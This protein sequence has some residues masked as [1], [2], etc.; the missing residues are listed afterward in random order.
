MKKYVPISIYNT[1]L[2][3]DS[4]NDYLHVV[5]CTTG[6]THTRTPTMAVY[7][8]PDELL[9]THVHGPN[10]EIVVVP[11]GRGLSIDEDYIVITV[12][13]ISKRIHYNIILYYTATV[14]MIGKS[15]NVYIYIYI[16]TDSYRQKHIAAVVFKHIIIYNTVE[17]C[18][19]RTA[20]LIRSCSR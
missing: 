5:H 10:N 18:R 11:S 6:C 3:Y 1:T 8:I 7:T 14:P 4:H 19:N 15:R 9:F 2:L 17:C 16:G 13:I 12:V 20:G